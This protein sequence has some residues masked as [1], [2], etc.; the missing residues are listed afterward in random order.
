MEVYLNSIEM[1]DGIYGAS[2]VAEWHFH[3]SAADL[4]KSEC[5]LIAGSLPNPRK[6]NSADPGPYLRKRQGRILREMR[7]VKT[8]PE[9]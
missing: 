6:Y 5:A 7:F 3:K 2:A 4:T 8:L 1:G 9:K